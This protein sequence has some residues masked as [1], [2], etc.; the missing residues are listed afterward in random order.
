MSHHFKIHV[1]LLLSV[2]LAFGVAGQSK[3]KIKAENEE[4]KEVNARLQND[5]RK[6]EYENKKLKE[7]LAQNTKLTS[8]YESEVYRLRKDSARLASEKVVVENE[9]TALKEKQKREAMLATPDPNDTRPC[10]R[11]QSSLKSGSYFPETLSRLHSKGWGIQIYSFSSL[12][13]AVEK[14][15]EFS[16][17]YHMY[18]TYIRVKETGG[19]KTY[20]VI[21]GTLKDEQQARIYL[22]NF[23]RI[24][25]DKEGQNAFLINHG[26]N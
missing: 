21:Y 23:K 20:S 7:D 11:L 19:K 5:K 10:A 13:Q 3:K 18:K 15:K 9:L 17:Y 12:C 2:F 6:L 16:Q 14:A 22:E 24:A 25:Q 26:Q 8:F 4:L 1:A